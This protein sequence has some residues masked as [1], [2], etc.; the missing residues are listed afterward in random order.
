ME[1]TTFGLLFYIRR[2]KTNKRG[3][4]PVFMRL[5]I[6]GERADASIKRF[7]EPH[8]WNSAKGKANEKSRGGKDLNLYLDAISANIL[9]IQRD[10]ELDKKEVSAQIILNR[11]LGK[12]QS[13]RHTLM[14]VFRAHNEKC[15][16]L[17]GISLAPATV[18]RYETTLRLTEEFLQKNYKKEDC[19]L[20]EVTNQFIEDF[21]FFLKTVRRCCHNTTTK[22]LL[23]FKKIIRIALAKGWMKKDPFAQV[24]FHFEPVEREFLEKQE[25]KA[26]LNK[27][28]TITRL[29]QVRDIFCFCCLTGLA[30]TDVQQLRP[31]HLVAD[32]H[33]K[34][35]I[36]KARQKTKNMCNIPLLD[37]AQKIIDR[38]RDHPYCQTHGVLLP[39]CSNQKM[40]SYLKELA[41]ICGI[42][43][44]LSTHCARHTFATLTLASGATIDNV[45]KMLGHANVN[46]TRRYAKVLDSSIMRD[47]EVVAENMAL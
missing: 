21:E 12:E 14:E 25:L 42:R 35:W 23:N 17:S 45:A 30:F 27:E 33:G 31:E 43:K 16:A 10:L 5:T 41:D 38:Y 26:M 28:I 40:N 37:E 19:Y 18:I 46:M 13:D 6:N 3:E 44:N 47:M 39:V 2:D 20:D 22:Y 4:A 15:R 7:I 24:H 29:A 1:R 36:R 8:A 32:I 34:I 11:Y 9:R